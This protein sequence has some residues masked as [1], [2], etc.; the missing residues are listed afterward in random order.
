VTSPSRAAAAAHKQKLAALAAVCDELRKP[1]LEL[2]D[3]ENA[4]QASLR[5]ALSNRDALQTAEADAVVACGPRGRPADFVGKIAA[6]DAEVARCQRALA[7]IEAKAAD[8][9]RR[10]EDSELSASIVASATQGLVADII[11]AEVIDN[12]LAEYFDAQRKL[13]KA[14]A[15]ARTLAG[16]CVRQKW[17]PL[18]ER[19]HVAINTTPPARWNDQTFPDWPAFIA[20]LAGDASAAVP[21]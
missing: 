2:A 1:V 17:M 19:V 9:R 6:A 21:A 15:K 5:T 11:A 7:A 18:A 20:A 8:A 10:L 3:R 12:T 13:A 14:E 4:A 16:E